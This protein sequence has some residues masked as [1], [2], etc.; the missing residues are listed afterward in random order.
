MS[1]SSDAVDP[2]GLKNR[3]RHAASAA[4]LTLPAPCF[5]CF[6]AIFGELSGRRPKYQSTV[7]AALPLLFAAAL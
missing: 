1:F 3:N 7:P 6:S 4:R 5:S 2:P